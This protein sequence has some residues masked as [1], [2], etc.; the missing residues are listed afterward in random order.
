MHLSSAPKDATVGSERPLIWSQEALADL[1]SIWDF[2]I[3]VAGQRTAENV[4]REIVETCGLI[5]RIRSPVE[6]GTRC[7]RDCGH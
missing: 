6:R 7:G 3:G 4:V 2:Y 5:E 1:E